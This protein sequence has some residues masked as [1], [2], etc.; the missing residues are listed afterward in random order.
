MRRHGARASDLR[1]A[2]DR[3]PLATRKAMLEGIQTNPIIVGADGD[4]RGGVC[5]VYAISSP[6]SKRIGKPFARAWDRYAGVRLPRE[7]RASELRTLRSMLETS[8]ELESEADV[9]L[10][11]AAIVAHRTSQAR[12]EA[13][14]AARET[15]SSVP[16]KRAPA[17]RRDSGE[18][19]RTG[20]LS[21]RHGWAWMRPVRR[22]DDYERA[23][24]ALEDMARDVGSESESE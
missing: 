4:P 24:Q 14:A 8:I 11:H 19:D 7:A 13:L 20:E 21:R 10:L 9:P 12:T 23:L 15:R 17:P 22:Y 5:P 6:P 2:V 1:A 18:R 3:L 16:E